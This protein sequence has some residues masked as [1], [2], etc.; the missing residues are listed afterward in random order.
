MVD[1]VRDADPLLIYLSALETR[2]SDG[3][4]DGQVWSEMASDEIDPVADVLYP[5]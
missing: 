5:A 2:A 3:P 4:A 1:Q